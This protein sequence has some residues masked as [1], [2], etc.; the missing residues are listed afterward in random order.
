MRARFVDL[1]KQD[2]KYK[3][4]FMSAIERVID[5][6]NFIMGN[7]VIAFEKQFAAYCGKK[8]CITLNSGTDA[9][10]L[11]LTAYGIKK[12]DE[13][14]TV[15]NSYFSTAMTISNVG[16][17]PVFIDID[18]DSYNMDI[19][20]IEEKITNKTK[21]IIPVHLYGQAADMD[22]ITSIANKHNLIILEDCCQ[23]HGAKYKD[24][25]V[26][27]AETG[28]FSFYPGKNLGSFG[29]GGAIVTDNS[30]IAEKLEY[31]RNDGSKIKYEH[32][33]FGS[34]SRLDTIQAAILLVKLKYLDFFV[35]KR[36]AAAKIYTN[37]L[38]SVRQIKTP[39]ELSYAKHAYHIYAI[40]C[41]KRDVLKKYLDQ[42]G[43]ETVIH[44][45]TPI[46]L[47]D[48]YLKRGFKKGDF[49]VAEH[50]SENVLSLPIF[51][52]I[53]SEEIEYVVKTIKK[54]YST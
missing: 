3:T 36:R 31:L 30:E 43:I 54:F 42:R 39:K 6:A 17:T 40:L 53:T 12:G 8:Y 27:I 16:A 35:E 49:P 24:K 7:E 4:E 21:A 45:P 13:V 48:A 10:Q 1:K 15:P 28:A 22:A 20:L 47:Q 19:K 34:K 23:A 5:N 26:P 25:I 44:Y 52:E 51:P 32:R 37:L 18:K 33:M 29:D 38:R 41:E 14:I 2:E 46:H 50:L 11:A 9:L